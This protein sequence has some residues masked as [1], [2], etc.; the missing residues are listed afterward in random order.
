MRLAA[1]CF[2]LAAGPAL[3]A[4]EFPTGTFTLKDSEGA[5]WEVTFDGKGKFK[6]TRD[7]VDRAAGPYKATKDTLEILDPGESAPKDARAPATYKWKLDGKKL[8]FTKVKD[9]IEGRAKVVTHGPWE[10]KE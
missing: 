5:V 4:D 3:A 6:V 1:I 10:K 8:T 2:L 7:G 9:D